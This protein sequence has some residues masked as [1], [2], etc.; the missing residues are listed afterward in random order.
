MLKVR[1]LKCGGCEYKMAVA[2]V[3]KDG[4]TCPICGRPLEPIAEKG[5]KAIVTGKQIGRAH[6]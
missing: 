6:V 5:S 3:P 4:W 2:F 1:L